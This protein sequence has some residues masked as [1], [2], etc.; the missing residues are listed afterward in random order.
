MTGGATP[1]S[2][3]L[4]AI[5]MALGLLP[6]FVIQIQTSLNGDITWLITAAERLVA[7]QSMLKSYYE[8]NPPLSVLYNVPPVLLGKI[9][10][11]PYEYVIFFYFLGLIAVAAVAINEI[12]KRWDF[13]DRDVRF[14]LLAAFIIPNTII[15][16]VS[17]GERDQIVLLGLLPFLMAQLSLTWGYKLPNKLFWP[18]MVF[19]VIAVLIK[20]H[21]GLLPTLLLVQRMWMQRRVFSIIR[22]AD[23]LSLAVGTVS[24]IA[25]VWFF[26]HDYVTVI[27][28]DVISLYASNKH[29]EY[30]VPQLL[31][32]LY[33]FGTFF[34]I[35]A[36]FTPLTGRRKLLL[37]LLYAGAL[38]C[39]VPFAVQMKA[40]YYHLIP[41][42]VF[43][44]CGFALS[45]HSYADVYLRRLKFVAAGVVV[46]LFVM[47]YINRPLLLE[48][49]KHKD[50]ASFPLTLEMQKCEKPC[51]A[52]MFN[53]SIE[54][55]HPTF[56]Y[57]GERNASRFPTLWFLPKMVKE[58]DN[59]ETL[60]LRRKY[61]DMVG[62]DLRNF[63]P[64]ML[65]IGQ[66]WIEDNVKMFDYGEF[67]GISDIFR[68]E[69]AHYT[70]DRE[71]TVNRK[72]YFAGTELGKEDF[73]M[74]YAIY[75][76]TR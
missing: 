4:F 59:P 16:T 50:Y 8:V 40:F 14:I 10:P 63:Q 56:F 43:F 12:A 19:G 44:F 71:I 75:M 47:A 5:L 54:V 36:A 31:W 23:F 35:E 1:L 62:E 18:V 49:P 45:L 76:R 20:P 28:P 26:F 53:D 61:A 70:K 58:P 7:G 67:F 68:E 65:L 60:P 6:W 2:A 17:I 29:Y 34:G 69:W 21:F 38:A 22:D 48:F 37:V 33:L 24:Y 32:H 42:I 52:F 74:T 39:L 66:Y 11:I 64:K 9:L 55:M 51:P 3:R 13:V 46:A 72:D 57:M 41:S 27:M 73:P 25:I 15:A 30:A